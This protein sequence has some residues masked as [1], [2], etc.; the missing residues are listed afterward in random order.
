MTRKERK[1]Y[2]KYQFASD[3]VQQANP[4]AEAYKENEV[5]KIDNRVLQKNSKIDLS[6][7][8]ML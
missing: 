2:Q 6:E 8:R 1:S 4:I 3:Q 5:F 7:H